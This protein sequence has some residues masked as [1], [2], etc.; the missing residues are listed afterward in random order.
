MGQVFCIL[1]YKKAGDCLRVDTVGEEAEDMKVTR[2]VQ[3][4][5]GAP[6]DKVKD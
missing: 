2:W 6:S 3:E 1:Y 5:A 4:C